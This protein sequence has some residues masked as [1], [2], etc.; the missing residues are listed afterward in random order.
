MADQLSNPEQV[1][2]VIPTLNEEAQIESCIRSLLAQD[3]QNCAIVIC[4]GLST[5]RTREIVMS[6]Q[7]TYP[8][9]K[10]LENE[11]RLQ[12][13]AINHAVATH[14]TPE[15][16]YIVRCDAH[17]SYPEHFIVQPFHFMNDQS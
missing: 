8:E 3:G 1:L 2:V 6:L 4:D 11:K 9:L 15:T 17:S 7:D 16:R 12:S 10:F 5:D 13:A 14:A